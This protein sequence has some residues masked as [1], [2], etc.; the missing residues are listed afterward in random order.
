L[1]KIVI[2][3]PSHQ[4][5]NRCILGDTEAAHMK[6][7]AVKA[8]SI[9]KGVEGLDKVYLIGDASSKYTTDK[10]RLYWSIAESNKLAGDVK[11]DNVIHVGLH[12]NASDGEATRGVEAFYF[13]SEGKKLATAIYNSLYGVFN[14]RRGVKE[15]KSFAEV[16]GTKAVATIVEC[17]FHTNKKDA[18][19]LHEVDKVATAIAKGILTYF[20]ISTA[21]QT[22]DYKAK[23]FA[24]VKEVKELV[25][26]YS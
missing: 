17:G 24:L 7:I 21:I 9:L 22:V 26:K 6:K 20:S 2:I 19:I 4:L 23:Y 12:S 3:N 25:A 11:K 13:S 14:T 5:F 8:Y 16:N 10:E 15:H 1:K 18:E